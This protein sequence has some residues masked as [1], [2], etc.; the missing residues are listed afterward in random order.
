MILLKELY[1]LEKIWKLQDQLKTEKMQHNGLSAIRRCRGLDSDKPALAE[2]RQ[3]REN[4]E[5]REFVSNLFMFSWMIS[6]KIPNS[7][8]N[9]VWQSSRIF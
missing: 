1:S 9:I 3:A 2:I 5:P 4:H 7:N 6:L 8:N